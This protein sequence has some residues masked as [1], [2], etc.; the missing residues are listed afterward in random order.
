MGL[1]RLAISNYFTADRPDPLKAIQWR[2]F[3]CQINDFTGRIFFEMKQV[4]AP[5]FWSRLAVDIAA[6][7]YFRKKGVPKS[8]SEKSVRAMIIRVVKAIVAAGIDQKYFSKKEAAIFAAELTDI[9]IH[10][11]A[12]FN[13][14]VWF[15]CGLFQSYKINGDGPL[16]VWN[17]K[18]KK[19]F[20]QKSSYKNPQVSACFIQS[21][22]DSMEG[23]FDLAKTEA[24]L[25][26]Y[27]SGSGT[28]FSSLRS[29]YENLEGGGTSSGLIS[30]LEVLDKGAGAVKSGGTTRRAAKM[31]ILNVDHPE[32]EE[33]VKWK[34][35]E[36][37]KAKALIEAGFEGSFEGEAY[38]TI[39]GQNANNSVRVTD[40]FMKAVEKGELWSLRAR[41]SDKVT[42]TINAKDLWKEIT[43]SAWACAD[44]GLQF[45]NTIQKWHTC[46]ST[47]PINASNPCSEYMFLDDSAC[48]LSSINLL[49]FLNEKNEFDLAA[50]VHTARMMLIAQEILVDFAGYP[51]EKI[52]QNS[53][54][55][56]PLGLGFCGLGAFLM[57]QA[58]PYDSETARAWAG[59]LSAI[60]TGVAYKT[61]SQIAKV[62]TPFTGFKKNKSTMLKVM[63]Q[64]QRNLNKIK[65][66]LL[67]QQLKTFSEDVWNDV[68]IM[69]Q[70]Y[71]FRNS[72]TTVM[73]PTGTIGLVMDC[74]T[75]GVEPEF[76]LVKFKKMAG[77]GDIKIIS[78]SFLRALKVLHYNDNKISLIEKYVTEKGTLQ[79]CPEIKSGHLKVFDCAMD[80][81]P[82][83]H[84]QMM[85]AIQPFIS[86]A[87]SK[88]VNM[89]M[90]CSATDISEIYQQAWSLGLKAI[91]IYRDGSKASQPLTTANIPKEKIK[92]QNLVPEC[93][94]CGSPTELAGGCFRCVN[95]GTNT[96]CA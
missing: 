22:H 72:Q 1:Q 88:T 31:V 12:F 51:T 53:H 37:K 60:L 67:P 32:I 17:S 33:F 69:G 64:H 84:L 54:D 58:I 90:D 3:D 20:E 15:N 5:D 94:E 81:V 68:Q 96:G 23:I 42:K 10:Q 74:D 71:G 26:K 18:T 41:T 70:K 55:F 79:G 47:A 83:A 27:G 87:I 13:S 62:K 95:C 59:S 35:F 6:S 82:H 36:E 46:A 93:P 65:W 29:K 24:M 50:Y 49:R 34:S 14:P 40:Q 2:K 61:S 57:S 75:T 89:P 38:R 7:K 21:I 78:T 48:N 66:P 11:R 30:F 39:S 92:P 9:L 52:A 19:I 43:E 77:G 85:A 25:F 45:H 63:K 44:P 80:I 91:A 28:N 16:W 4:E 73:A 8:G 76:S 56:R 86:G